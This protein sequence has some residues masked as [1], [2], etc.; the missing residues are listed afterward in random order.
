MY[1]SPL[2]FMSTFLPVGSTPAYRGPTPEAE[3]SPLGPRSAISS[4]PSSPTS[5]CRVDVISTLPVQYHG[6]QKWRCTRKGLATLLLQYLPRYV[7]ERKC[8][9]FNPEQLLEN[10][11]DLWISR[12]CGTLTSDFEN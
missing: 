8:N 5:I 9:V 10:E 3:D 12:S 1:Y 6:N 7:P 11:T 4:L 2:L